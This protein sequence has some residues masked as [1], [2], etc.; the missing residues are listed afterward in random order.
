MVTML[1]AAA[2]LQDASFT[3]RAN[4]ITVVKGD[5]FEWAITTQGSFPDAENRMGL[6]GDNYYNSSV[7]NEKGEENNLKEHSSEDD[8]AR[9][10]FYAVVPN[11]KAGDIYLVSCQR[12]YPGSSF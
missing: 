2:K 4:N 9:V 6:E 7:E 12:G 8:A 1:P 11:L 3:I 10:R 5:K